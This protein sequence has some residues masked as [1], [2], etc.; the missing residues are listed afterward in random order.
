MLQD[1]FYNIISSETMPAGPGPGGVETLRIIVG[2]D[3]GHPI[4]RGHFPGNPVVPGVCEI[5]VVKE[6]LCTLKGFNGML[7]SA[8]NIK[9]LNI[10]H[11]A[12]HPVL[13]IDYTL[14]PAGADHMSVTAVIRDEET[15]FMKFKGILCTRPS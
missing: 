5:Q 7:M 10:I 2:L 15:V 11:P 6:A 1:N 12:G 9:F 13:A 8:E 14:K 3:A 4:Y